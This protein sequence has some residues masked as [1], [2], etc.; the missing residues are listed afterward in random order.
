MKRYSDSELLKMSE[1]KIDAMANAG[2]LD[3]DDWMRWHV[4]H[5]E[6]EEAFDFFV[7]HELISL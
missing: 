6:I 4:L 5:Q 1:A 7:K 3:D 2:K